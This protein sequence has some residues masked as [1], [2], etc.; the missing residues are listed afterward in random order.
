VA[1]RYKNG[2]WTELSA[3]SM[4]KSADSHLPDGY[5]VF[6][7]L[8]ASIYRQC[9]AYVHSDVRS[10]QAQI[11]ENAEGIVQIS[12]PI[13]KEHSGRLGHLFCGE[14]HILRHKAFTLAC[15][16]YNLV[17]MRHLAAAVAAA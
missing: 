9:S 12:Q 4:A 3:E 2:K 1:G 10:I 14:R 13:S 5:K 6:A 7:F 8:Y 15:A 16:A 11:Q 17:R